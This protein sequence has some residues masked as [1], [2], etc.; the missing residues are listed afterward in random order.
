MPPVWIGR[1]DG[2][3]LGIA[4][5]DQRVYVGGHFDA[6]EP[7]HDAECLKHIPTN[8]IKSGTHH[9]H[10]VAFDMNGKSDPKWT[11]QADTSE[12]PTTLLAGPDALYVGGNFQNILEK[13]R[14]DGGHGVN[15]PG[16]ALFP[17]L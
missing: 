6:E 15:H 11:A 12:G 16:F 17:A 14:L 5:T 13:S 1:V 3:V 7:N 8:C 4:A 10:L 2:D 9:R